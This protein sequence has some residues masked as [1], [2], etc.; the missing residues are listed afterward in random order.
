MEIQPI[1]DIENEEHRIVLKEFFDYYKEPLVAEMQQEFNDHFV[2]MRSRALSFNQNPAFGGIALIAQQKVGFLVYD[3]NEEKLCLL[4]T[5]GQP[6][7]A[8]LNRLNRLVPDEQIERMIQEDKREEFLNQ[9]RERYPIDTFNPIISMKMVIA[10]EMMNEVINYW[11]EGDLVPLNELGGLGLD[12][13]TLTALNDYKESLVENGLI[14]E[15]SNIDGNYYRA[16]QQQ[17]QA[18]L[19]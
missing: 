1:F 13:I 3:T 8:S 5:N 12:E 10:N 15:F 16:N 7:Q 14:N 11:F 2:N 4:I 6:D 17:R 19:N 18:Y 9:I